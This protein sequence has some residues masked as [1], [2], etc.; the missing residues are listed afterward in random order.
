MTILPCPFSG[1][2]LKYMVNKQDFDFFRFFQKRVYIAEE[3]LSGVVV[4]SSGPK[5]KEEDHYEQHY[6]RNR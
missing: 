5:N 3:K 4:I 1:N 2:Q 6:P